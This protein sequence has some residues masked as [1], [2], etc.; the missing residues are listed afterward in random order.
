MWHRGKT[1]QVTSPL[2]A[3]S[4]H[5]DEKAIRTRYTCRE[6]SIKG[7]SGIGVSPL[8]VFRS[9]KSAVLRFLLTVVACEECLIVCV[10]FSKEFRTALLDP[11]LEISLCN[12][13]GM[14]EDR[15][16]WHQ[17]GYLCILFGDFLRSSAHC[18][19]I[20]TEGSRIKFRGL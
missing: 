2:L 8:S 16:V 10:P 7:V 17:N 20:R 4:Q 13:I 14:V 12:L 3:Q 5:I 19:R 6:L 11:P 9:E 18:I 15:V 1:L